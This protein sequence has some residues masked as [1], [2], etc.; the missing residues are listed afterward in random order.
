MYQVYKN[1]DIDFG[2]SFI[3][4]GDFQSAKN[5]KIIASGADES[6]APYKFSSE[7]S[8]IVN[9]GIIYNF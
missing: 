3:D 4:V 8:P 7:L 5:R 9:L 2:V 6:I 1:M